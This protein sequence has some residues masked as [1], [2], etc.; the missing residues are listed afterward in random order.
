M[1]FTSPTYNKFYTQKILKKEYVEK[2]NLKEIQKKE[3]VTEV[4]EDIFQEEEKGEILIDSSSTQDTVWIENNLLKIGI[5][6]IGAAIVSIQMKQFTDEISKDNIDIIKDNKFGGSQIKIGSKDYAKTKF[7]LSKT[8]DGLLVCSY[9]ESEDNI[10][11]KKYEL[12]KDSYKIKI[13]IENNRL[14]GERLSFLWNPGIKETENLLQK[15]SPTKKV[16]HIA[17]NDNMQHIVMKKGEKEGPIAGNYN[18]IGITSKYF[19][20]AL[21]N[22]KEGECDLKYEAREV[23]K[24]EINYAIE[25]NRMAENRVE[26]FSI[27]AG[28]TRRAE[29]KKYAQ[30]Y[31]KVLFPVTGWTKI[32]FRADLWFPWLADKVLLLLLQIQ[33]IVKDYGIAIIIITLISKIITY[34]MTM[35]SMKSMEKMKLIQPK[36][37]KIREKHK[38]NPQKMNEEVMAL[39]KKEGVNPLNPGCL[40]MFLQA[41]VFISLFVVLQN[42][43]EIRGTTTFLLPWVH[44]LSKPEVLISLSGIIPNGIPMYGSNIALLPIIMAVLTFFQQKLTIKDPNQKM[45]IY[46]MPIF[47]LVLFNSFPSGLVLYW[48]FSSAVQ[49]AQQL[50]MTKK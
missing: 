35:S 18:W 2:N 19:L 12:E 30:K 10:I 32:F 9:S 40:P 28:P 23:N 29:L 1:F 4:K 20:L 31:E 11:Y 41:P 50:F 27:Y 26:E 46:F 3:V 48:T 5:S 44:D 42:A 17:S 8:K 38:N 6:E 47:M 39:Y 43:I 14:P 24:K 22:E 37:T 7:N 33:R 49:L 15:N 36:V 25:I 13:S 21:N 16:L 34:P 45:M